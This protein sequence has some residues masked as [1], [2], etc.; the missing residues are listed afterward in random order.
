[1]RVLQD[2]QYEEIETDF[3]LCDQNHFCIFTDAKG[4]N[5]SLSCIESHWHEWLEVTELLEGEME[6]ECEGEKLTVKAGRAVVVG[7]QA[8]HKI[9]GKPGNYAFRCLHINVGFVMQNMNVSSLYNKAFILPADDNLS[10]SFN[11]ISQVIEKEDAVSKMLLK[12]SL[13]MVLSSIAAQAGQREN[14]TAYVYS[15]IFSE[16]VY[17]IAK[18]YDEE[19]SLNILSEKFGYTPQYISSLFKKYMNTTF[20]TYLTRMRMDRARFLLSSATLNVSE[21][22]YACGFASETAMSEKFKKMY[23]MTPLQYKR[24]SESKG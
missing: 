8:L 10:H 19:L 17:Y 5:D 14:N 7:V 21:I 2:S 9:T 22:A 12:A 16:I 13:L 20:Y 15:D 4:Y 11:V 6:L 18:H 1:M 23:G 24:T 3:R